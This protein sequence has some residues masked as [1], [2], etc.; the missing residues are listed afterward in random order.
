M[1]SFSNKPP[2]PS[3][4]ESV[5]IHLCYVSY[6][7]CVISDVT[8]Y[9]SP[10]VQVLTCIQETHTSEY[11]YC[12]AWTLDC[13]PRSPVGLYEFLFLRFNAS[14]KINSKLVG[15]KISLQLSSVSLALLT[16]EYQGTN[17]QTGTNQRMNSLKNC[18]ILVYRIKASAAEWVWVCCSDYLKKSIRMCKRTVQG[19][20]NVL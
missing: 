13:T 3:W 18:F 4:W 7:I 11:V 8:T 14:L 16:S 1:L 9:N 2:S 17:K 20:L 19:L 10:P 5:C 15:V 12:F 6:V